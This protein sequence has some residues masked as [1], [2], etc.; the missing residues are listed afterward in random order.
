MVGVQ[1][2]T[3]KHTAP[4][5]FLTSIL[6]LQQH[7]TQQPKL[8]LADPPARAPPP[9]GRT[10]TE[11][12]VSSQFEKILTPCPLTHP[13]DTDHVI[14]F[15]NSAVRRTL[16][17][18]LEQVQG[19]YCP[20]VVHGVD[21][22][23]GCPVAQ[24]IKGGPVEREFFAAEHGRWLLTSAY[25]TGARSREGL[26]LYFHTVRDITDQK[27]AQ[28]ALA[29]SEEKYRRLFAEMGD[30]IFV[31]SMAGIVQDMNRAGL[32]LFRVPSREKLS[33][34]N[35]FTGLRL[36]DSGMDAV[37]PGARR[38]RPCR[39]PRDRF[40]GRGGGSRSLRSTPAWNAT[41]RAEKA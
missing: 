34:F 27:N 21:H 24:A 36:V 5:N 32:E 6:L 38:A 22:Y 15:A 41:A 35:L 39:Q 1:G 31:M 28:K 37:H 19:R 25:P 11:P 33:G 29:E 23:A 9:A 14:Q 30:A 4:P 26:D 10:P 8:L 3:R 2:S 40:Q 17:L 20:Q 12:A 13:S 16:G 7:P 18:T